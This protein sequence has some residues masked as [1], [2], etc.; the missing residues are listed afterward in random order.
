MAI[1]AVRCRAKG[2][3]GGLLHDLRIARGEFCIT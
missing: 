2:F 3:Q 1:A